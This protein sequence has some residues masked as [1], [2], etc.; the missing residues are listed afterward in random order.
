MKNDFFAFVETYWDD[1]K[2]FFEALVN[3]FKAVIGKLTAGE[4][5]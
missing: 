4:E 1:I 2:A 3:F 5:E